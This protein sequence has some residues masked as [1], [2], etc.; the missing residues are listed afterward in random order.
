MDTTKCQTSKDN[1]GICPCT[2]TSCTQCY[3]IY[4]YVLVIIQQSYVLA[5]RKEFLYGVPADGASTKLMVQ[6]LEALNHLFR[7]GISEPPTKK[8]LSSPIFR[9]ME[10]GYTFFTMWLD[11]LLAQGVLQYRLYNISYSHLSPHPLLS[12]LSKVL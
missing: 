3:V 1:A 8:T 11:S 4:M 9:N 12:H 10:Q 6:Y 5:E 2:C 7:R